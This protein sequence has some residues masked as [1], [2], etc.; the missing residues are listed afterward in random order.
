MELLNGCGEL[1]LSFSLVDSQ[2][3]LLR[4]TGCVEADSSLTVLLNRILEGPK[5][6]KSSG[7]G[8]MFDGCKCVELRETTK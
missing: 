1:G 6:R 3:S 8:Q 4:K 7:A 5:A 2:I